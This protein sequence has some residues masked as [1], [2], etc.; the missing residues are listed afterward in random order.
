MLV[1]TN[2]HRALAEGAPDEDSEDSIN[3]SLESAPMTAGLAPTH[4]P[5]VESL[6]PEEVLGA[7]SNRSNL[8][9]LSGE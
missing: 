9:S 3:E 7:L 1:P 2:H 6:S 4:S 8:I 5:S